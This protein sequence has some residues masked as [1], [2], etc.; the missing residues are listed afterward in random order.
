LSENNGGD[1]EAAVLAI[2]AR[3]IQNKFSLNKLNEV[4]KNEYLQNRN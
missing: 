4:L 2:E 3:R 1:I